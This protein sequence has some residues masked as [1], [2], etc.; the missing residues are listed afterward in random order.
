MG[1]LV[2]GGAIGFARSRPGPPIWICDLHLDPSPTVR[3]L[4]LRHSIKYNVRALREYRRGMVG[5][6]R[7]SRFPYAEELRKRKKTMGDRSEVRRPSRP[8]PLASAPDGPA[9][10][11]NIVYPS[12]V[13]THSTSR[14]T[15]G[16]KEPHSSARTTWGHAILK[17]KFY[18]RVSVPYLPFG[19]AFPHP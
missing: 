5:R 12:T 3:V 6:D 4:P 16:Q 14:V 10:F 18:F 1:F 2:S 19:F 17:E 13:M 7:R 9:P 8:T 15:S 11:K